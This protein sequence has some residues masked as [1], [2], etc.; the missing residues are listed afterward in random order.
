MAAGVHDAGGLGGVG[1]AGLL[2]DGEGVDVRAEADGAARTAAPN[3]GRSACAGHD[4]I[5]DAQVLQAAADEGGS[6]GLFVA[7][8]R[9]FMEGAENGFQCRD[10]FL[11]L[12]DECFF[13]GE[14]LSISGDVGTPGQYRPHRAGGPVVSQKKCASRR[15]SQRRRLKSQ[16]V[17]AAQSLPS[18]RGSHWEK[19]AVRS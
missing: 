12:L 13:H 9:V 4:G 8:F 3:D 6:L 17:A 2:C 18:A 14:V 7:Q 19:E 10:Q 16:G 15:R 11:R 1:Q 5:F